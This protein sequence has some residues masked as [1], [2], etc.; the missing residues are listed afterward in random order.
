ML[1]M[2]G[3]RKKAAYSVQPGRQQVVRFRLTAK[4]LKRG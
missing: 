4:R 1:R 2:E 3:T